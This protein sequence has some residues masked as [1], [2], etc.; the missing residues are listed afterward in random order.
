MKFIITLFFFI[1]SCAIFAQQ[2][3]F[4]VNWQAVDASIE[5]SVTS[6]DGAESSVLNLNY[7]PDKRLFNFQVNWEESSDITNVVLKN[8][9]LTPASRA[10]IQQLD[11]SLVTEDYQLISKSNFGR[12][13][14]Y[15]SIS[16]NPVVK[17]NGVI[18]VVTSFVVSYSPTNNR[19]GN[20]I[21][22][23]HSITN[24]VF[25]T[26]DW[27]KF[28][29]ENTGVH[30]ITRSFLSSLG[31]NVS[32]L[33]SSQFKIVGHGGDML[34]L[35][36]NEN[37]YY[38]PPQVPY[39][40]VG[41]DDG[42]F[43]ADDYIL[44]Y[45][46]DVNDSWSEENGTNLNLYADRSYYYISINSG[47]G[48]KVSSYTEPS[49]TVVETITTFDDYQYYE[50]DNYNVINVGRRWFAD[51]FDVDVEQNYD[52]EFPNIVTDEPVTVEV[53]A[54]AVS[55]TSTDMTFSAGEE[56]LGVLDFDTVSDDIYG[57]AKSGSYQFNSNEDEINIEISYN[58][59]GNP[60]S[61]GY[62]DY[63]NVS[64]K[65]ELIAGSNQ[66]EFSN[67]DVSTISGIG[68]YE[69][70]E[71][72][73][74]TEVWDITNIE[75]VYSISN[76]DASANFSFKASLGEVR[77][78]I[79]L[80]GNNYY[81]PKKES[82]S[83]VPNINIK[84]DIFS[85]SGSEEDVDYLI[86]TSEL[87]YQQATRLAVYRAEK[88]NLNVKVVLIE[89]IY[90][91]FSSGKQDVVAIRNLVKYVY[92]NA[93]NSSSRLKYVCLFGDSSVDYKDRL[94]QNNNI[95]PTYH[96]LSSFSLGPSAYST[97]DFY[98]MMDD[99]EGN[100]SSNSGLLDIA[101]GRIIAD[102]PSMA[103]TLVDKIIAYESRDSFGSWRNNF[104]LI[105]DDADEP[106]GSGYDLQVGLD[107]IGDEIS[108]NKPFINVK[109]IHSDAYQQ[110]SSSGGFR[111]P[112]VNEAI[113]EA[114][115]VGASV[116]NYFGHGGENGLAT[117]R[118]VTI[119]DILSWQNTDK[120]NLF[121]TV[122]CEFTRYDNPA[123]LSP[124]EYV[125]QKSEGGSVAM[126]TTTRAIFVSTGTNFNEL[127]APY[128]FNYDGSDDSVAESVRKAKNDIGGSNV[129]VVYYF[130]DPA[131]KLQ[132]AAPQIKLTTINE[133]PITQ[134]NDTLKA[135]SYIK[136]GGEVQDASGNLVTAYNG[137]LSTT[138]FDKRIDRNTLN[139]DGNGVFDFTTLGEIIFRG[140]A[141]VVNGQFSFDFIV[142]KD[143]TVPVGEGR[144][145]FYAERDDV[146]ED[147][148]GYSSDI[149]IGGI[150]EDAPEDNIG[151]EI[152]LFMND[153][154]FVSGG[155]T[156]NEPYLIAK[157]SDENGINTASGIGHDL[158]AILDGDEIN[159]YVVNDYYETELDDYTAGTVNYKLRDLEEGL[160]T[161]SFK[162]WD[163]Y[164]NSNTAEIQFV[165]AGED[166]LEINRVLNYP[167]PFHN[168]TEFWFNH[169]RPYEPLEVQV[170]V[171][172]VS[173][174]I[175]WTKNQTI[176]TDGFLS[177]EITWNGKDDFGDTIGKGVYIY[178]LSVKSTLTNK[179]V[180]KFEKLV[181]L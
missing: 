176:T 5:S 36:N 93:I 54:G 77:N 84:G 12:S 133:V 76:N 48:N 113:T 112:E 80:V 30:K 20:V 37:E 171:F 25:A 117:E 103:S 174:K 13:T 137:D 164:N 22:S 46:K 167:N 71:S 24:S 83:S 160:H 85:T 155:I 105:S 33:S 179:K 43:D 139:N 108:A 106:G 15:A 145:S 99:T 51:R 143:I 50:V 152:E 141:S 177:R 142:P 116:V 101:V 52:F 18:N 3:S 55:E 75:Q 70:R 64:A 61:V 153:E 98:G 162:A 149:L 118:I 94:S 1:S 127:F 120:Y 107:A 17:V 175:V 56:V 11:E 140:K 124:G 131:M 19:G 58:N 72:Q 39:K 178:K 27:Y 102:T 14:K 65:R 44:F 92:D 100:L 126:V 86:I 138:I 90:E 29:V 97:D 115:E 26:G 38:D 114:I 104:V 45:A 129:R 60:S 146:L 121:V 57:S 6:D 111:Y 34:P 82:V 53:Y 135:L 134:P 159:P 10:I 136:L 165:V 110:I 88:D 170:Q 132:L 109:K 91:E 69:I 161:L 35:T 74:V 181:I 147:E 73:N 158:V 78:Y 144:V 59:S 89:D 2:K 67:K 62:L 68:A 122:T 42:S 154:N 7:N 8:V 172:T 130:G 157:L 28:Y 173:G 163:V 9:E 128:L 49:G 40:V 95:V 166:D 150:N 148:R 21:N 63:I 23:S 16:L 47:S 81:T 32:S 4:T 87:L 169:N 125:L 96:A 168:Y 66:F 151:P 41:G 31:I 156:N 123:E 79:A 180:E 119:D